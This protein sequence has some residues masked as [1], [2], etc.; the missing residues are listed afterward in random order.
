M[1]L[2]YKIY[3]EKQLLYIGRTKQKLQDRL[4][5]HFFHKPLH[6]K[7]AI[8]EVKR[9]EFAECQTVAD[10]YL[11]EIYYINKLHPILNVDDQA[12]DEL[13]IILPELLFVEYQCLL[14][15]KWQK[16][17]AEKKQACLEKRRAAMQL[18]HVKRKAKKELSTE[19]YQQFL[20]QLNPNNSRKER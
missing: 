19:A 5:G 18:V 16:Q 2:I 17:I 1:N 13:T 9:I 14:L 15:L 3:D 4:R 12:Q 8:D 20:E 10:M 11:Y 7:I 6:K